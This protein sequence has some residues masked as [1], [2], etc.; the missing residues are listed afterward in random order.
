M[1]KYSSYK[2]CEQWYGPIPSEWKNQ[3]IK[4]LFTLHDERNYRPLNEVNLI[5]LYSKVGVMQHSDI[6]H[7]TGNKARNADGYKIVSRNDI[8]VNILLCWMGAIG[9]SEYDGITSPAYDI[10]TPKK[11]VNSRYYHYLFRT[12]GFSGECYKVGKG[13]MSMRWRTYSPQFRN[14]IVPVPPR[15]EQDQIVRFLDW[16]VSKINQLIAKKKSQIQVLKECEK[17]IINN[18]VLHGIHNMPCKDS[19]NKWI[20]NIPTTW[21]VM[22]LGKFCTFQNGISESGD[23]FTSGNPFVSY[24]DVYRHLELPKT[25]NGVARSNEQHEKLFSVQKG[26]IFFTR[27]SENIEE[28]G[29]A[30][31]CKHTIDKAI[32]S[33]FLIRCR[34]QKA[35][36]D[37]DYIKYYLQI[38]AIRNHFSSQMNIVIRASLSQNLLKQMPVVIPPLKEQ[39]EIAAYLDEQHKKYTNLIEITKKEVYVLTEL[40]TRLISDVVTGQMDVR[41][42]RIP[43]Y[44]YIEEENTEVKDMDKVM[45]DIE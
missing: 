16:K 10:Y 41:N 32:F 43:D 22:K 21:N 40:K 6:E 39:K 1:K 31:V 36:I 26:D 13:I 29:M 19:G 20:G 3:R 30:A 28:I 14:I 5:S 35:I 45:T 38:P 17:L 23:F 11:G 24:G 42:I 2:K 4:A 27:T 18:A 8:I 12:P 25:V 37:I 44:K 9:R 34:P 7:T 15:S 33:G